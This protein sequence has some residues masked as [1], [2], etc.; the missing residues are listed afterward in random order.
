MTYQM[1]LSLFVKYLQMIRVFF[2]VLDKD[3]SQR[4]LSNDLSIISEWTLRLKMQFNPD[5]NKQATEPSR[6]LPAQS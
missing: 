6:H 1:V 2:K 3:K 5:L 4:D